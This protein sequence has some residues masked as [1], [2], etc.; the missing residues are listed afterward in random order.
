MNQGSL[1]Y[2]P[3]SIP[4]SLDRLTLP[5]DPSSPKNKATS[6]DATPQDSK[7][8]TH[9]LN[10]LEKEEEKRLVRLR[11]L[12][13]EKEDREAWR[14]ALKYKEK[15]PKL[16]MEEIKKENDE[17]CAYLLNWIE[18]VER[19]SM[20]DRMRLYM[21]QFTADKPLLKLLKCK[22]GSTNWGDVTT[23]REVKKRLMCL[24]PK[25]DIR[26]ATYKLLKVN[27][28]ET[29]NVRV[30]AAKAMTQYHEVCEVYDVVELPISLNHVIAH[31]VTAN[32]NPSGRALYYDDLRAD[33]DKITIE[34]EKS[35]SNVKF[36]QSL[37]NHASNS[38]EDED[39]TISTSC[40]A[41]DPKLNDYH[42][43]QGGSAFGSRL[44]S[45]HR[46]HRRCWFY[47]RGTCKFANRCRYEH[48]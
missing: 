34:M 19:N 12:E 24:I 31:N 26:Q 44:F 17:G 2:R 4:T 47:Q 7:V 41:E 21:L 32:M 18:Q 15:I 14:L 20:G 13:T 23:W 39:L 1:S 6:S 5:K 11:L 16:T 22:Q 33:V 40:T 9:F 37:F 35:F 45:R 36:K 46:S 28:Q 42:Y 43:R 25:Y 48:I 38:S 27:M 8:I 10:F 29:D 30:F 3:K